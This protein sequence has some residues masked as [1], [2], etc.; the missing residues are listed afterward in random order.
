MRFLYHIKTTTG[1]NTLVEADSIQAA[2]RLAGV[3]LEDC[4]K[5]YP[6]PVKKVLTEEEKAEKRKRLE[7]VKA[8]PVYRENSKAKKRVKRRVKK[9]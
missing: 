5:W 3:K 8:N 2:C 9:I 1:V 4:C 6:F 7:R